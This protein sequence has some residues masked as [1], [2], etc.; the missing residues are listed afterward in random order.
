MV[1]QPT[2]VNDVVHIKDSSSM[3]CITNSCLLQVDEMNF[4]GNCKRIIESIKVAKILNAKYRG[5]PELEITGY[6]CGDHFL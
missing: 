3:E 2:I 5:G 4:N 6:G 1:N